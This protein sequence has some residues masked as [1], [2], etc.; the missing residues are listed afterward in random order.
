M[1]DDYAARDEVAILGWPVCAGPKVRILLPPARS[2]VRTDFQ[3]RC[4]R[5]WRASLRRSAL[6]TVHM[7]AG[8]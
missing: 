4:D 2:P 3:A 7:T 8:R 6:G 1:L 5:R